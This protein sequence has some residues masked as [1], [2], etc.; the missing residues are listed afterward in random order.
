VDRMGSHLN[1][2]DQVVFMEHGRIEEF[3]IGTTAT[4]LTTRVG[5][6]PVSLFP[7]AISSSFIRTR[8]ALSRH[9]TGKARQRKVIPQRERANTV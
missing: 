5:S 2:A 8:D 4:T 6:T 3:G 9:F 1:P 7:I